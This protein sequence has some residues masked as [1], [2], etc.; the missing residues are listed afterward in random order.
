MYETTIFFALT[1]FFCASNPACT[2]FRF[3]PTISG[4]GLGTMVP[5]LR[6]L[7]R[8]SRQIFEPMSLLKIEGAETVRRVSKTTRNGKGWSE[9]AYPSS[10]APT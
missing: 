3:C 10:S 5:A 1:P 7:G 4:S 9:N 6:A 8:N 2:D